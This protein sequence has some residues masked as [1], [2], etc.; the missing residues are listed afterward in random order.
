MTDARDAVAGALEAAYA[1]AYPP[2][3]TRP[4]VSGGPAPIDPPTTPLAIVLS[5]GVD[6]PSVA[7]PARVY[8][9]AI[10]IAVPQYLDDAGLDTL[11]DVTLDALDVA[12]VTWSDVTRG[13]FLD[14]LP[15][16]Q[17]TAECT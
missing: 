17:L 13:A 6:P 15:A 5:A 8:R 11:L 7:C 16:Y 2:G 14:T 4:L 12:G 3:R 10:T 9:L 1:V